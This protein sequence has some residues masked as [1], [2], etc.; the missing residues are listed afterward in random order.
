MGENGGDGH[1]GDSERMES[2]RRRKGNSIESYRRKSPV[3]ERE[4]PT[5][6]GF[7]FLTKFHKKCIYMP[8]T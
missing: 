4:R 3:L 5:G 2:G 7:V 6:L 8:D 1:D